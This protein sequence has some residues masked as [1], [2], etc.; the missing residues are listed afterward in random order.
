M[1]EAS[2]DRGGPTGIFSFE[3]R[4][5]QGAAVVWTVDHRDRADAG[6]SS[7]GSLPMLAPAE[8]ALRVSGLREELRIR[9]SVVGVEPVEVRVLPPE[10]LP[11]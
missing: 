6:W 2:F 10:W 1:S 4:G 9:C 7:A 5:S 3:V 11:R 8:A